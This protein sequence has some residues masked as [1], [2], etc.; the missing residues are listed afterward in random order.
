M[1]PTVLNG[2]VDER[3]ER[4]TRLQE[5]LA[6]CPTDVTA[7]CELAATLER[8]EQHQEALFHWNAV[9]ARDPNNLEAR[10]GVARCRR[11]TGRSLVPKL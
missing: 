2:P 8:L 9:L 6:A 5:M 7:R 10:E 11:R 4:L 3:V 1:P